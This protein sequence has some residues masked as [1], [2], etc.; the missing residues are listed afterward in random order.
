MACKKIVFASLLLDRNLGEELYTRCLEKLVR[1]CAASA[2][3][4]IELVDLDF[5]GRERVNGELV[6]VGKRRSNPARRAIL[7]AAELLCGWLD[8]P[9]YL[10]H[11]EWKVRYN[12]EPRLRAY[13]ADILRGASLLIFGGGGI[14]ECTRM[15][16]YYHTIDL[17]TRLADRES[18]PVCFNAVGRVI[19]ERYMFGW[20]IMKRAVNRACVKS[21]TCRDG[22][23]W[24]DRNLYDGK[25][26]A[27]VLPCSSILCAELFGLRRDEGSNTIGVGV[28]RGSAFVGYGRNFTEAQ[29]LDLYEGVARGLV[30]RGYECCVFTNGSHGD[31]GFGRLLAERLNALEGVRYALEPRDAEDLLRTIAS[32]RGM[33]TA[34]LHSVIAAYSLGVP[35]VALTWNQKIPDFMQLVGVPECALVVDEPRADEV[36]GALESAMKRGYPESRRSELE[37]DVREGVGKLLSYAK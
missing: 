35:S 30:A 4:E 3:M 28:I 5:N 26:F 17:I 32:F 11:I 9:E 27:R 6:F 36:I 22:A 33:V 10:R 18:V 14:I 24:I 15:H 20:G 8:W 19:D 12:N 29:M 1:E 7:K 13:F 37:R 23:E 31:I 34:R 25:G 21:M 2:G 16:D